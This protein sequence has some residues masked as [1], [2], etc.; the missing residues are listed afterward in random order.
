[1]NLSSDEN[2]EFL[3]WFGDFVLLERGGTVQFS[4]QFYH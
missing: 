2:S 4:Y 1:M 3:E